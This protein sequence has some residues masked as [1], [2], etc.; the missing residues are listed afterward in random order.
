[1]PR[2]PLD[3]QSGHGGRLVI[4]CF[5]VLC[6]G[7]LV[8]AFTVGPASLI[9][10]SGKPGENPDHSKPTHSQAANSGGER[11]TA[12]PTSAPVATSNQA[13]PTAD[14]ADANSG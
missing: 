13:S 1:M 7:A 6:V 8:W 2:L 4:V 9:T 11:P 14:A 10:G 3:R 12:T 5:I